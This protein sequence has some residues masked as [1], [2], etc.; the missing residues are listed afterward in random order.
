MAKEMAATELTR[1]SEDDARMAK[2]MAATE[3]TRKSEDDARMAEEMPETMTAESGANATSKLAGGGT[4][5]EGDPKPFEVGGP[6]SVVET[7][8]SPVDG[9]PIVGTSTKLTPKV[10]RH[11]HFLL[12]CPCFYIFNYF[13]VIVLFLD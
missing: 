7:P 9:F 12:K 1:K 5:N 13:E 10:N 3:L 6:G 2:E 8:A 4:F 11:V